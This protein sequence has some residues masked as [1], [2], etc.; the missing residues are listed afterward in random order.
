MDGTPLRVTGSGTGG[1]VA[2]AV[3]DT[4]GGIPDGD[5][6]LLI[7]PFFSTKE[8]GKGT[9]LG[10]SVSRTIVAGAGGEIRAESEKGKGATFLVVLPS[11][12]GT[13]RSGG[14]K[15]NHG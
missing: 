8:P 13:A 12:R 4:G 1:G 3:T 6:P 14:E 9:G 5:L 7:D 10:V 2:L 15:R 11:A